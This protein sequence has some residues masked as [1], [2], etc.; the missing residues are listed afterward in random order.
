MQRSSIPETICTYKHYYSPILIHHGFE[1]DVHLQIVWLLGIVVLL[2]LQ[3]TIQWDTLN[4]FFFVQ[5]HLTFLTFGTKTFIRKWDKQQAEMSKKEKIIARHDSLLHIEIFNGRARSSWE[6][7]WYERKQQQKFVN[8]FPMP[9]F[10][11]K[12]RAHWTN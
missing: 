4:I 7:K 1:F 5:I 10:Q 11:I 3:I 9:Q 12:N 6:W 2:H 8:N